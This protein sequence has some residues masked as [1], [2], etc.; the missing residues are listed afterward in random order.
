MKIFLLQLR[1]FLTVIFMQ[2][3][4][5][6]QSPVQVIQ[7]KRENRIDVIIAGKIFTS[8]LYPDTLE[9]PVLYPVRA[10]DGKIITRGFPINT[11]PGEPTDHPHHVG[12]WFTYENLNGLDF[13]NNSYA[14]PAGKKH[15]YGWIRT[16]KIIKTSGGRQGMIVYHANWT[17]Q[18]KKVLLEET[19]QLIFSG[20][21]NERMI[22]RI[23]TLKA[24]TTVLFTDAKDGLYGIRLAHELQIPDKTDKEYYDDKGNVTTVRRISDSI[25]NGNY[26]TSE[27]KSGD[28]AWGTRGVWCKNFGKMGNDSISITIIDHPKNPGYPTFWHARGYGLFAANPLGEKIFSNGNLTRNLH[29]QKGES[30]TFRYRI[31]IQNGDTTLSSEE[32]NKEA[33]EFA[34]IK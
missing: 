8:F 9:K 23:T 33:E 28:S 1:L 13:W 14:I 22:D 11:R 18:Q 25:A 16:D 17:N 30:V 6:A 3:N 21:K 10:A 29:L 27:R 7:S 4:C 26:L 34:G 31:I 19:T 15:L 24:D 20:T 32:L 12:I 2:S 5:F